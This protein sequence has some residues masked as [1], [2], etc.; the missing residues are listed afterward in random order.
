VRRIDLPRDGNPP[1][2]PVAQGTLQLYRAKINKRV[3]RRE[4]VTLL[5]VSSIRRLRRERK[6]HLKGQGVAGWGWADSRLVSAAC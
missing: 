6:Q 2:Q 5:V 4:T 1:S 3:M